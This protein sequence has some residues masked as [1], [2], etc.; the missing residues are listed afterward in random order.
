M[1]HLM[2]D[3]S[4]KLI[5]IPN[6]NDPI[7]LRKAM[8][9]NA[10]S[11]KDVYACKCFNTTRPVFETILGPS[12]GP[13]DLNRPFR[14]YKNADG[15]IQ[16]EGVSTCALVG[17]GLWR[18]I[19]VDLNTL[20]N[21]YVPGTAITDERSF[22]KKN[23][24]Y[25][26]INPDSFLTTKPNAGDYVIVGTG[27]ALHVFTV[28]KWTDDTTCIS[29]DGG[30]TCKKCGLQCIHEVTRTLT[31][32]NNVGYLGNRPIESWINLEELPIKDSNITVPE[33]WEEVDSI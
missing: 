28:V 29:I 20:Y 23:G 30:Q 3:N 11:I 16:T 32:N 4:A 10:Y 9:A 6:P 19:S 26:T 8:I 1:N 22:G 21:K 13:W 33:N 25:K 27:N 18:R 24:A 2:I 12:F 14:V 17:R 7:L 5:S 15:K 31:M